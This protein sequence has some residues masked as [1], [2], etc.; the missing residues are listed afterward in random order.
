[1]TFSVSAAAG[2]QLG[3]HRQFNNMDLR[4]ATNSVLAI[5]TVWPA[6][7]GL[8]RAVVTAAGLPVKSRAALL[9]LDSAAGSSPRQN[10]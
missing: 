5:K 9:L 6:Q 7:A 2:Q 1:V 10:K 4:G 3:Y 8:C